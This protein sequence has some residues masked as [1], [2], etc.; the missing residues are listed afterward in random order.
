ML[1]GHGLEL[2][3]GGASKEAASKIDQTAECRKVEDQTRKWAMFKQFETREGAKRE[4]KTAAKES[5]DE[6]MQRVAE[7]AAGKAAKTEQEF[8]KKHTIFTN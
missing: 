5:A 6:K 3:V 7:E 8:D 2:R 4:D 1:P